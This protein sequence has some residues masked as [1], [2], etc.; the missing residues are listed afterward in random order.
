M[1]LQKGQRGLGMWGWIFVLGVIGFVTMI[2]LQLIPIYL[3]EM[4]I[5]RVVKLAASDPSNANAGPAEVR[6]SLQ[7]RWDVEGISTL[8]PKD[9]Q[10]IKT[11]NGRALMYD[12][13]AKADLF[14]NLTLV[15]HFHQQ[16]NMS[17]TGAVE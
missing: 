14:A 1:R 16:F 17:G 7:T 8:S 6:K 11:P 10:L 3:Q 15:A 12:Y 4:S 2:T 9:V 13:E 5:Q